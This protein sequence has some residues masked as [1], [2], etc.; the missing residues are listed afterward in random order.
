MRLA[1]SAWVFW[2][3]VCAAWAQNLVPNGDFESDA[4][5]DGLADHWEFAGDRGVTASWGL[6]AG[7]ESPRSQ[8]LD[9]SAFIHLSPASHAM[10]C[11]VGT[12]SLREAQW[13][14]LSFVARG[15]GIAGGTA[16][17]ML[18]DMDGWEP[19]S[20]AR[21]F[22]V[23]ADWR[24]HTYRFRSPRTVTDTVRLQ[25][26]YEST[27]TLWLDDVSL[28][29]CEAV[30]PQMT[31][32]VPAAGGKNLVPNSSFEMGEVA[33]GSVT[34]S[35][36]WAG[37]LGDLFG[38]IDASTAG[39]HERSLRIEVTSENAPVIYF[40]YFDL[41]RHLVRSPEAANRGWIG[42][43]PGATYTLS[44]YLRSRPAGVVATLGLQDG[45]WRTHRTRVSAEAEWARYA[46][47]CTPVDDQVYVRIGPDLEASGLDAATLWLDGVQLEQGDSATDYVPR[48]PVEIGLRHLPQGPVFSLGGPAGLD[49]VA[50]NATAEPQAVEASLTFAGFRDELNTQALSLEVAPHS[51]VERRLAVPSDRQG[52]WR[53]ALSPSAQAAPVTSRPTR[54]AVVQPYEEPDSLFG[55]NHAYPNRRLMDLSRRI[56]LGWFRDW[57]LK[58]DHVEPEPGQFDFSEPDIQ[59]NRVIDSGCQVLGLLPFPSSDW[60]SSAPA[61]LTGWGDLPGSL[62]R[63]AYMPRD[64]ADYAAYVRKCVDHYRG[65]VSVWEITNEPIYTGYALPHRAGYEPGDYVRLLRAAYLAVKEA[66]PTALVL[67]GIAGGPTT[68]TEE[69]IQAGGL[70]CVDAL[71]IHIYPGMAAPEG[72]IAGF[73]QLLTAMDEAG[74]P[75]PIWFTEGAYYADDDPPVSP[76]EAWMSPLDTEWDACVMQ[77]RFNVVLLAHRTQRIIYHSGTC[78]SINDEDMASVFFEYGAEPRK[79]L[80]SQATMGHL[81][82]PDTRLLARISAPDGAYGWAFASRGSVVVAAWDTRGQSTFSHAPPTA[83]LFDLTGNEVAIRG[84]RLDDEPVFLVLPGGV[85][86]L[87]AIEPAE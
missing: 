59:I 10:L 81:L 6:D 84:H 11:Q 75:R 60:A 52:Y 76:Y 31:E 38:E 33:W 22:R 48:A 41:Y 58:W 32:T 28:R 69:F 57:S 21:G 51:T 66:D 70:Q 87:P 64:L 54:I 18:Q 47:T 53:V 49:V 62:A 63:Q 82:G 1:A 77:A 5:G 42:V 27:G 78:G 14:E 39:E 71:T 35:P 30:R 61:D 4:D 25:F 80:V 83:R 7:H 85:E 72:Y 45:R 12:V 26:W 56:G 73:E 46:F 9:C 50:F 23:T 68:L 3:C 29:E 43:T 55:M 74:A 44:A 36:T 67:G 34:D 19:L 8:R 24:R 20:P 15:S 65:R 16:T 40:D 13:Y 2:A 86:D 37:S 79:M 17:V